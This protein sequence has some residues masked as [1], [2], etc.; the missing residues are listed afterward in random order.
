MTDD[1][2]DWLSMVL[3]LRQHNIDYTADD[4]GDGRNTVA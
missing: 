3:R 1:D 4:D 2:G